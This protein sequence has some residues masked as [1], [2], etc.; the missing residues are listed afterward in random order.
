MPLFAQFE[1]KRN[2]N[3]ADFFCSSAVGGDAGGGG[4]GGERNIVRDSKMH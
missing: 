1:T 2:S 4:S 3:S